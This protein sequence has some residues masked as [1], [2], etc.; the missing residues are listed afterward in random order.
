[1]NLKLSRSKQ[2]L[3]DE[4]VHLVDRAVAKYRTRDQ[5]DLR[6]QLLIA[7]T[8]ACRDYDPKAGPFEPYAWRRI[9]DRCASF[10]RKRPQPPSADEVIDHDEEGELTVFDQ[11]DRSGAFDYG[12]N[13]NPRADQ[14]RDEIAKLEA[15]E[16]EVIE[17]HLDRDLTIEEIA[18]EIGISKSSA[19]RLMQRAKST[20]RQRLGK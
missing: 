17:L 14:L 6:Q 7:L 13:H 16:R 20:L 19:G 5:Q 12:T 11:A 2:K 8:S 1:M 15:L 9:D 3:F 18:V 10:F 4:H